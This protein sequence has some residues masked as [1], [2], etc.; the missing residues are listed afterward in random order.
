MSRSRDLFAEVVA[1]ETAD[2]VADTV[3]SLAATLSAL[4]PTMRSSLQADL[5]AGRLSELDSIG[6]ELLRLA[7]RHNLAIP[8]VEKVIAMLSE[9][10]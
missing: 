8:A 3:D 9:S 5:A 4:P 2:G 10:S 6:G 7:R 1:C